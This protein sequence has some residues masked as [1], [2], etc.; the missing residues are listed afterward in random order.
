MFV[1]KEL[2]IRAILASISCS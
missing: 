1:K 2:F